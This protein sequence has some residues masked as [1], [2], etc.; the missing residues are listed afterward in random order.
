MR[1]IWSIMWAPSCIRWPHATWCCAKFLYRHELVPCV[2]CVV[3]DMTHAAYIR[4]TNRLDGR[5]QQ[6]ARIDDWLFVRAAP[7]A[8]WVARTN[9]NCATE[10]AQ[11]WGGAARC[12]PHTHTHTLLSF[13]FGILLVALL[14]CVAAIPHR[15]DICVPN[16]RALVGVHMV[17]AVI[18][19]EGVLGQMMECVCGKVGS[20]LIVPPHERPC[21]RPVVRDAK[22]HRY[23]LYRARL[24]ARQSSYSLYV[25]NKTTHEMCT[26]SFKM[27]FTCRNMSPSSMPCSKASSSRCLL[28]AYESRWWCGL[29]TPFSSFSLCITAANE[30]KIWKRHELNDC[31]YM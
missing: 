5:S 23:M 25:Y 1:E 10:F 21:K 19:W 8:F 6:V 3:L 14:L 29:W 16:A 4:E 20:N 17:R 15:V 12:N 7:F 28:L 18:A 13:S 27:C 11:L 26:I 30:K 22:L 2:W 24:R 9:C 31:K